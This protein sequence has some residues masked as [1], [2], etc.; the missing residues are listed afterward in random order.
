MKIPAL[1]L[2]VSCPKC[3]LVKFEIQKQD[4]LKKNKELKCTNCRYKWIVSMNEDEKE[5]IVHL[6]QLAEEYKEIHQKYTDLYFQLF[7]CPNI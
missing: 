1:I 2:N 3:K 6:L 5:E 7:C 4:L